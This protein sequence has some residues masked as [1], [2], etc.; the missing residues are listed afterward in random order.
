MNFLS[1]TTFNL[2]LVTTVISQP[3]NSYTADLLKP[4]LFNR[5]D[6]NTIEIIDSPLESQ[7][8]QRRSVIGEKD[9]RMQIMEPFQN[10]K[11]KAIGSLENTCTGTLV[12]GGRYVLTAAHCVYSKKWADFTWENLFTSGVGE[13][14]G[15]FSY[16][17]TDFEWIKIPTGYQELDDTNY[18]YKAYDFALM[19]LVVN[20]G[21]SINSWYELSPVKLD[22]KVVGEKVSITGYPVDKPKQTMWSST[23][24]ISGYD[25]RNL[26][27]YDCDTFNGMSGS[28][29][30]REGN[31]NE[32]GTVIGI[33]TSGTG[34]FEN[35][36]NSG[37]LM[38]SIL[39]KTLTEYAD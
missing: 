9:S 17:P 18:N 13:E 3:L 5:S 29:I 14:G 22:E 10:P 32:K 27:Q 24:L 6:T 20:V 25:E 30:V 21:K 39:H 34:V 16:K 2:L 23:C 31:A 7:H 36:N 11:T 12:L 8:H 15:Q 35:D 26:V 1:T 33:H 19:K 38:N 28:V 4:V 37:I